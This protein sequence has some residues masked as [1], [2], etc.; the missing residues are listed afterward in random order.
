MK[1]KHVLITLCLAV[2]VAC[3]GGK[4]PAEEIQPPQ[5]PEEEPE[6]VQEIPYIRRLDIDL[7]AE[8]KLIAQQNRIFAFDLLKTVHK[9]ED[10]QTNIFVSPLS[11]NLA[12][13]M[14]NNGAGGETQKELENV[15]GAENIPREAL[16][17]FAQKIVKAMQELDTRAVFESAN[18]IWIKKDFP[19]LDPFKE[20]NQQYFEAEVRNEDFTLPST[21]GLINGWVE[22]KTHGK[23]PQ[24]LNNIDP[25]ARMYLIN[26][27]YFK[28]FWETPFLKEN[29]ADKP[30]FNHDG[31]TP[32]LP[33][34]HA[35]QTLGVYQNELFA[36]LELPFGNRAFALVILLPNEGI[37][38]D[39]VVE[40]LDAEAWEQHLADLPQKQ[41]AV[42]LQLP[43][44][45]VEYEKNLNDDLKALGLPSIF[46][47]NSD[48]SRINPDAALYVSL[49]RQKTFAQVDETGMEAA[50]ATLIALSGANL[51]EPP[52]PFDF[53]ANRPFLFFI[54][55][56]STGI[57]FFSGMIRN[58]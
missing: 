48:F 53:H 19:V 15:L 43:R 41:Y 37:T 52:P 31:S 29:T 40:S 18:S 57:P 46:T 34:M 8:E 1:R 28:G 26:T 22:E 17:T 2:L 27:L 49:V 42:N 55:E 39:A 25:L 3:Q 21:L 4:E 47:T 36:M 10:A 14:L 6:A 30:F 11:L 58:L 54:K 32:D 7:T 20:A 33:T 50:A 38:L 45:K 44:F 35:V 51:N 56:Q 16:N 9:N 23:V 12:L 13:L 24:I 5:L